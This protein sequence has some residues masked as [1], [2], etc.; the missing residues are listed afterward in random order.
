MFEKIRRGE[1]FCRFLRLNQSL[2][3]YL[4]I[5]YLI[6]LLLENLWPKSISYFLEL[7]HL[8]IIVIASGVVAVSTHKEQKATEWI[9]DDPKIRRSVVISAGIVGT[10]ILWYK[11]HATEFGLIISIIGGVSIAMVSFLIFSEGIDI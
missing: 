3:Q 1:K 11:L 10:A 6:F 9:F 4:L 7:N 8:L 5:I 2:F